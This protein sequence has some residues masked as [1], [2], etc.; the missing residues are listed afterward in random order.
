MVSP[1]RLEIYQDFV[2]IHSK[3]GVYNPNLALVGLLSTLTP[4]LKGMVLWAMDDGVI[5]YEPRQLYSNTLSWLE[6]Q[7][8]DRRI[9][10]ITK[11]AVWYYCR[12]VNQDK[13]VVDGSL[14]KIGAVVKTVEERTAYGLSRTGYMRSLAGKDLAIPLISHAVEFVFRAQQ[15]DTPPKY[16]SMWRILGQVSSP[17]DQR[18]PEIVYR[19]IDFLVNNPGVHRKVDILNG[20]G[21]VNEANVSNALIPLGKTGIIDYQSPMMEVEGERGKGWAQYLLED[22]EENRK[23]LQDTD[24]LYLE[25][26]RE[27]RH[28]HLPGSLS[29]VAGYILQNPDQLHERNQLARVL[30]IHPPSISSILSLLESFGILKRIE[31]GFKGGERVSF[32]QANYL[33]NLFDEL[34]LQPARYMADTLI[35]QPPKPLT[36]PKLAIFLDNYQQERSHIG[37]EGAIQVRLAIYTILDQYRQVKLSHLIQLHNQQADR[38]LTAGAIRSQLNFLITQRL[39]KKTQTGF[40][41]LVKLI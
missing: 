16:D 35:P 31:H 39:V 22:Q 18:R 3:E 9:F 38:E 20:L 5:Y 11:K 36:A 12:L 32:V 6:Q 25:I 21:D 7:G 41:A 26:K 8:I 29:Q 24:Q 19:I 28:F 2:E 15:T 34:I 33:T 40:Y 4:D 13:Q 23:R 30:K 27:R 37:S 17:T 10:P 1:E 14:V